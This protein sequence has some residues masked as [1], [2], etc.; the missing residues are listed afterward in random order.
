[1]HD[2]SGAGACVWSLR[3]FAR[4]A[5][6]QYERK[7]MPKF[8]ERNGYVAAKAIQFERMDSALRTSLWNFIDT[9]FFESEEFHFSKDLVLKNQAMII[10]D[11]F[12]KKAIR[13]LPYEIEDF[14]SRK[15]GWFNKKAQWYEVYDY[16]EFCLSDLIG[17]HAAEQVNGN[18]NWVLEREKSSYR[19]IDGFI[20]PIVQQE[21]LDGIQRALELARQISRSSRAH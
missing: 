13:D 21:Q 16:C 14:V 20:A 2:R 10:Y 15:S 3:P 12:H 11:R 18:L 1:M 5:E 17:T 4:V 8:S 7:T 9:H 6:A 19:V